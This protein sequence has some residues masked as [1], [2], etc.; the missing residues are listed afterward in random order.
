MYWWVAMEVGVVCLQFVFLLFST[1]WNHV[2]AS[3]IMLSCTYSS[4]YKCF[5]NF[6]LFDTLYKLE[7][8][9]QARMIT[10]QEC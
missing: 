6:N 10:S 1:Q 3:C 2:L 4:L 9:V 7:G 5:K 8:A